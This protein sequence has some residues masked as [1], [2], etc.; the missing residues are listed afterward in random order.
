MIFYKLRDKFFFK[1]MLPSVNI[2]NDVNPR[3]RHLEFSNHFEFFQL[4][5]DFTYGKGLMVFLIDQ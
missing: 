4:A 3:S 2:Q 1:K 5:V